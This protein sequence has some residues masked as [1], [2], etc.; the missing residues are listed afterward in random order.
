[1]FI[2]ICRDML[3]SNSLSFDLIWSFFSSLHEFYM[4]LRI[5]SEWVK[6]R[7][8]SCCIYLMKKGMEIMHCSFIILSLLPVVTLT[9]CIFHYK[10]LLVSFWINLIHDY[11]LRLLLYW[12]CWEL[13][14]GILL[15]EMWMNSGD[16]K[17]SEMVVASLRLIISQSRFK[18]IETLIHF[19]E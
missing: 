1:M 8:V 14:N 7:E 9:H 16:F 6:S 17:I 18:S 15:N 5:S 11:C 12:T 4:A 2:N 13:S 19:R 3:G 10:Y